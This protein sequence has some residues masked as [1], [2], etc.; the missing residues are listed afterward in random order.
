M[1]TWMFD[2][3]HSAVGFSAKHMMISTVRGRFEDFEGTIEYDPSHPA[4]SAVGVTIRTAS[5]DTNWQQ[6]D[7]HLRSADFFDVE[8]WPIMTFLSTKVEPQGEAR[9][10]ITGDLTIRGVTH[11]VTLDAEIVGEAIGL[12]GKRNLAFEARTRI[13]RELWGL[14]WNVG[15]ETG[16]VLVSKQITIELDIRA[17]EQVP[18]APE[19]VPATASAVSA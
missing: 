1:A 18:A 14:T 15:L 13:D 6:R 19:S 9:A 2:S 16:G 7:D 3:S 12:D 5:V 8:R 10:R 11:P 17:V 4:A